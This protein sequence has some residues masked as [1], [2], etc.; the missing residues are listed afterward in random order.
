R[1]A[2]QIGLFG[3]DIDDVNNLL[4]AR[5]AVKT[6]PW[7]RTDQRLKPSGLSKSRRRVV[8]R[9][10]AE[11]V[12]FTQ[13]HRAELGLADAGGAL[14][15]RPEHRL[16]RARRAPDDLQHTRRRRLLLQSLGE[17][18]V[19]VGVG[20]TKAV[21]VSSRLRCLRTRTGNASSALRPFASQGHLVGTVTGPPPQ[22]VLSQ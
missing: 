7:A 19:Q 8:H 22:P 18:L 17:L 20:C 6:C 21:N 2:L 9:D 10:Y 16:Q 13:I 4:C 12:T 14:Q 15:H 11:G 3:L 5:D 1:F